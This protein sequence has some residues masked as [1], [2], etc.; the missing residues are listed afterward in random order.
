MDAVAESPRALDGMRVIDLSRLLPG[1][2]ATLCLQGYGATVVK[3][4][5]PNG[6]DYLRN[7]P[8]FV[9]HGDGQ[10][11][12]WFAALNRGKRSVALDLRSDRGREAVLALLARADVLVESFRPG[13]LARLGLGPAMLRERF[14]RLVIA[15]LTGWG[16]TGPMASLPGH[17]LGFLAL[18]GLLY[19]NPTVPPI[20]WGDLAAGGLCAALQVVAA[21]LARE[22]GGQGA[23]LDVAML[24]NLVGLQ[25]TLFAQ[26]AAGAP[27]DEVLTGGLPVYNLYPAA[28]GRVTVAALEP[29]FL[30]ALAAQAPGLG[31]EEIA[32]WLATGTR[33]HWAKALAGACVVP[34]LSPSEVLA[35]PQI[36]A[37]GLF[38]NGLPHP[39]T[40]PVRG[41][42]PGLG[43][44]T[45][46][47]LG[48]TF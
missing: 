29:A 16:Q 37:R 40:G 43:E 8:P 32:A 33:D 35:H 28:D 10:V 18:A 17:D 19:R 26:L 47:E 6:G 14:P 3:V 5:D 46:A 22:R 20:Q 25:Q 9:P 12:A 13:V 44:H 48:P 4:E 42:V 39:P 21:L 36:V 11:N 34:V 41:A 15:S 2:F 31:A 1:P 23:W 30:A 7:L 27:P 45:A 24:D 38:W